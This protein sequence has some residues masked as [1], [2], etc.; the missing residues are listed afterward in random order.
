MTDA[1]RVLVVEDS[2]TDA[3]LIVQAL[4]ASGRQVEFQRVEDAESTRAA[5]EGA[6]W[7]VVISDWSMPKFTAAA[8]LGVLRE[9]Q[10]DLPFIIVSGTIGEE[11]A[12]D[13]MRA[14]AHDFVLKDKLARLAPAVERELREC[15]E[16]AAR[17]RAESALEESEERLREALRAGDE[18][19]TIASHGLKAPLASLSQEV[20]SAQHL[21]GRRSPTLPLE[22]MEAQLARVSRQ[23]AQLTLLVNNFLDVTQIMSKRMVLLAET[24]DLRDAL[25]SILAS[26]R[27]LLDRSG[28]TLTLRADRPVVG[29]WDS[30]RLTSVMFSLVSNAIKYGDGKPIDIELDVQRERARLAVTDHGIGISVPEQGRIL[31]RFERAVPRYHISGL[32]VGLWVAREIVVAHAG[33][34]GVTSKLGRGSTFTVL[35]PRA[36]AEKHN[37]GG[38][39]P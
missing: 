27:D 37:E 29:I 1:L 7:D 20:G 11:T 17:R 26:A 9:M 14:G 31:R 28:S 33:T 30:M 15:E 24:C 25:H 13:A 34:I 23:V 32:G 12:I 3:K 6:S 38:Q 4:R 22:K 10:L 21:L 19:L 35:L 18:F 5:L 2:A 36:P 8:A 16:R 39:L